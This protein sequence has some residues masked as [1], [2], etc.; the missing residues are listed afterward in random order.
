MDSPAVLNIKPG[1]PLPPFQLTAQH[2]DGRTELVD[3]AQLRGNPLV[4]F[5]YPE[6]DTPG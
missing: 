1:D 4:L 2:P 6:A 5:F 3:S